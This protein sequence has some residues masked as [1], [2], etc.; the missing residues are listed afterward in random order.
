MLF[1]SIAKPI[2][3]ENNGANK[4]MTPNDARIRT[5]TY[6]ANL[7]VDMEHSV[8]FRQENG[9]WGPFD[10]KMIKNVMIGKIPIMLKSNICVLNQFSHLN[11]DIT[12]ECSHDPGGY[13]IISGSEKT[14]LA[15]ER[16]AENNVMCF[17]VKRNNNRWSWLAEIKSIPLN[18]CISPKQINITI[19]Y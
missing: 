3:Q 15:Q 2:I 11:T 18:K 13:F 8:R 19:L 16:A 12:K 7:Y 5:I 14:I 9:E 4:I 17:N 10:K 1:R 6:A